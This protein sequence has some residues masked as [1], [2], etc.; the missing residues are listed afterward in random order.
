MKIERTNTGVIIHEA[1]YI[2]KQK[3]L[4]YF[5]LQDP[6]REYFLYSG[7]DP[8]NK[9]RFGKEHDVIYIT[10]G[11]LEVNDPI[12]MKIKNCKKVNPVT[13]KPIKL[14]MNKNPRSQLQIDCINMLTTSSS[15]KIT[16]ELKPGVNIL[17]APAYGDMRVKFSIELLE[18]SNAYDATT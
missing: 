14:E 12:I 4:E 13:P 11:F 8:N 7:N 10:S 15:P 2:I 18:Y 1:S 16:V 6:T 5:S 3:C 9:P 17:P